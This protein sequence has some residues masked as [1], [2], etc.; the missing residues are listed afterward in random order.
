MAE[1]ALMNSR[2]RVAPV[3]ASVAG[4]IVLLFFAMWLRVVP[5]DPD[6]VLQG[7]L[8]VTTGLLA[9][10]FAA[11]TLVRFQ[12]TQDRISLILGAGFLLS[13]TILTASSL[14]FFQFQQNTPVE[15][16]WARVWLWV[17]R[18]VL[19]L[20]FF[21][22]L[23]VEHFLP[24][25]RPPHREITGALLTVMASTYLIPA[26]LRRLP[27]E[28]SPH[29]GA[30]FPSPLQLLPAGIF[31]VAV[32]WFRRRLQLED[33]AFDRTIYAAA[34]INLGAQLAAS[35]SLRLLDSPFVLAQPLTV[36][37]YAI[38]LVGALLD[39]ARLFEPVSHLAV[40]DPLTGLANYRRLLDVLETETGSLTAR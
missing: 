6:S 8:Q 1:S 37:S 31:L 19:A 20:L 10:V 15:V 14:L 21:V 13:G 2:S 3:L 24:R 28:V 38:A 7:Y 12:G 32:I 40:S 25:S 22:A 29:P 9:F 4:F 36:T 11:V 26:A 23:L 30:V 27:P 34:C 17:S 33:S 18:V 35:Q 5:V 39:N 16:R